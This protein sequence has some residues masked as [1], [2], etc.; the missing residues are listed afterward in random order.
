M[1]MPPADTTLITE[2]PDTPDTTAPP[3]S[4]GA[5]VDTHGAGPA[6]PER[7][8]SSAEKSHQAKFHF[9]ESDRPYQPLNDKDLVE[10]LQKWGMYD[11]MRVSRFRFDQAF[12]RYELDDFVKDFFNDQTGA[13]ALQVLSN[14]QGH[15][16]SVGAPNSCSAVKTEP[17]E[18]TATSMEFFD[19]FY[20]AGVVRL[21]GAI[22]G[23]VPEYTEDDFAVNNELSKLMLMEDS[24]HYD[25]FSESERSE[26]IFRL[27]KHLILGGPLNQYED[28]IGPYFD[29]VKK[30]YKSLIGVGKDTKTGQ[31]FCT[32]TVVKVTAAEGLGK[33]FPQDNGHPQNFC[34]LII[35]PTRRELTVWYYA[36]CG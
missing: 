34:Y 10:L 32:S 6:E 23:C 1:T 31:V 27:F 36:W 4:K 18:C 3:N 15:W 25:T 33:L 13:L 21:N 17:V 19:R 5:A 20:D 35:N 28:E 12:Q 24:D 30:M 26:L 7:S 29:T 14:V 2:L 22:C 8:T 9:A 16:T 11:S